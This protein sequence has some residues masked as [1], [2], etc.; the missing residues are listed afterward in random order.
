MQN[1]KGGKSDR[2]RQDLSVSLSNEEPLFQKRFGC[3][4]RRYSRERASQSSS[5][6]HATG[7]NF[8]RFAPSGSRSA[9]SPYSMTAIPLRNSLIGREYHWTFAPDEW[10]GGVCG[11]RRLLLGFSDECAARSTSRGRRGLRHRQLVRLNAL[12]LHAVVAHL[13]ALELKP[14]ALIAPRAWKMQSNT[15]CWD[16]ESL[17]GAK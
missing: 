3:E 5:Y 17:S 14:A 7:F 1:F 6:F 16:F 15:F 12:L 13:A 11:K 8:R 10:A 9:W 2:S 4:N